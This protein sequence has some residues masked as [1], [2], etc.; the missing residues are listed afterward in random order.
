MSIILFEFVIMVISCRTEFNFFYDN[1][2]LFL[3]RIVQLFLQ[4]I[5]ILAEIDDA[6]NRRLSLRGNLNQ[7]QPAFARRTAA[8]SQPSDAYAS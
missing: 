7:I 3:F 8:V 1:R 2:C 5:L 4:L 6:T